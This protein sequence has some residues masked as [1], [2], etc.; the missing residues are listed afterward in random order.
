ME[1]DFHAVE[2]PEEDMPLCALHDAHQVAGFPGGKFH[3]DARH[4][5]FL[6]GFCVLM[7]RPFSQTRDTMPERERPPEP[8]SAVSFTAWLSGGKLMCNYRKPVE[9]GS[10][11]SMPSVTIRRFLPG[12]F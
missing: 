10:T 5:V 8:Y 11:G 9:A 3:A 6:G 2:V 12:I 1:L 7:K 4:R